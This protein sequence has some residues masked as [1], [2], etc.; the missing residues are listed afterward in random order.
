MS[1]RGILDRDRCDRHRVS[2]IVTFDLLNWQRN[3]VSG[4]LGRVDSTEKD[5]SSVGVQVIEVQAEGRSID[6][7]LCDQLIVD[8]RNRLVQ[9][10][11][12]GLEKHVAHTQKA[13]D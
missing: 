4:K 11:N 2:Q 5:G 10:A 1:T 7:A 9:N 13:L 6:T 12:F 3:K 8:C